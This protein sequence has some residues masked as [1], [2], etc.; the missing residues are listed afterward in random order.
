MDESSIFLEPHGLSLSGMTLGK[1][2]G[3]ARAEK[4]K[5]HKRY[6]FASGHL[7]R[8]EDMANYQ[9][10]ICVHVIARH[11]NQKYH[12]IFVIMPPSE[13]PFNFLL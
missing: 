2:L 5:T 12:N 7:K 9:V 4:A 13:N 1:V 3:F 6:N 8:A 11:K 10:I